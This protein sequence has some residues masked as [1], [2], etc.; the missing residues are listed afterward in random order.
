VPGDID[1]AHDNKVS[2]SIETPDGSQCV[3]LFQRPDGSFGYESYRRDTEDGHG[4]FPTGNYNLLTFNSVDAALE[5]AQ[6]RISWLA[7]LTQSD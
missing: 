5:D 2:R 4:W 7:A 1:M 6:S 3:D